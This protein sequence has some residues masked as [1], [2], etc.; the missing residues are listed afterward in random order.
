MRIR[1]A[2]L[3]AMAT[4]AASCSREKAAPVEVGG[5]AIGG[6]YAHPD[7]ATFTLSKVVAADEN[8]F[9]VRLYREVFDSVPDDVRTGTL[10]VLAP[11]SAIDRAGFLR[12]HPRLIG[13]EPVR[14][15]EL[16]AYEARDDRAR[17]GDRSS[18][19]QESDDRYRCVVLYDK[20]ACS[21]GDLDRALACGVDPTS[22]A[23]QY[24]SERPRK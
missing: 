3:M 13:V 1:L 18:G 4:L 22:V 8:T 15:E 21:S 14:R 16:R 9:H 11:H 7:G 20:S 23:C 6:V 5:I 17:T 24:P 19:S 2:V 12:D 10:T